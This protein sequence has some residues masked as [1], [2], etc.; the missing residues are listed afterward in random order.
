MVAIRKVECPENRKS[1]KCPYAMTPTRIVIHNTANDAPAKNE[2]S[3]MHRNGNT[4]SFH[5]AVDDKE[6]VQ[7]IDLNRNALHAGDGKNGKGNREGI[8]IEICYS[9]CK[10]LVNGKW[11]ADE[12][13]WNAQYKSKFEAAQKN[14]AEL[15]A[16]LLKEYGW[17]IDKVTKHEDYTTKHC[18]HR[19]LDLYGWEYFIG[20][21]KGFMTD[22]DK[23]STTV[24]K[25][26]TV[27]KKTVD[28]IAAEVVAGKWGNGTERKEKLTAAG[29]NYSA[30][31][32][33]VNEL[34]NPSKPA[35][36]KMTIEEVAQKVIKGE[37]GN[38]EERKQKITAA[39]FDYS[40]VQAK[41]N[42]LCGKK[43]TAPKK[44]TTA[45]KKKT[46]T[47]IAKEVIAGKWGNG[48]E[49]KQKLTAAGYN[50]SSVQRKVNELLK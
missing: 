34:C 4:T 19:T 17:G 18:P 11:V 30:V 9:Y 45:P 28:E 5:F 20:L 33:K 24:P 37:Y 13:K 43:A 49:R 15:T 31:Q 48:A 42:E 44:T 21:V 25:K 46:V 35:T 29:Y 1:V 36:P 22:T 2:I 39:G 47:E 32:A 26:E 6:I 7:G 14:A 38:G 50:Y 3:Y 40:A 41:V 16:K 8:A 12:E 10:K 23:S 27:T